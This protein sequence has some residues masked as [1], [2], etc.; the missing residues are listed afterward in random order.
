M[1]QPTE[2]PT[3]SRFNLKFGFVTLNILATALVAALM[4]VQLFMIKDDYLG[5]NKHR[6]RPETTQR[7]KE[8]RPTQ[9]KIVD[10][11]AATVALQDTN[12]SIAG[13]PNTKPGT[14]EKP[15]SQSSPAANQKTDTVLTAK[16]PE[17]PETTISFFAVIGLMLTAGGLGGLMCNLRG[18]FS[19][20]RD[21]INE[22]FPER[23]MVPYAVRPFSSAIC[24]VFIYFLAHLLVVSV[25][26]DP[27]I[28]VPFKG[29][30]SLV[31]LA[32]LAGFGGQEL[33]ERMKETAR[34]LFGQKVEI[35][36]EAQ[37]EQYGKLLK[38]G[39]ITQKEFENFKAKLFEYSAAEKK[40]LFGETTTPTTPPSPPPPSQ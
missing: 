20:Y 38:D 21:D 15:A 4:M 3:E 35:A 12:Q 28:N 39:L 29:M 26:V 40:A 14:V 32:I 25:T 1:E 16:E 6:K 18:I 22:T 11:P 24:G 31:G 7:K 9:G 19:R 37:L 17:K 33:M 13:S 36:K 23:L 10:T 8:L 30:V 27:S 5:E 34:S 2:Q